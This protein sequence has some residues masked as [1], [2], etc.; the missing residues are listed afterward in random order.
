MLGLVMVDDDEEGASVKVAVEGLAGVGGS[1]KGLER[2]QDSG[3]GVLP[4]ADEAWF[5]GRPLP[6]RL[7]DGDLADVGE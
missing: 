2:G 4:E 7:D 5:S 6:I 3:R 1:V